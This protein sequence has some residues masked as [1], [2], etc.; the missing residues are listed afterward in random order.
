MLDMCLF[1]L[2]HLI[3][4]IEQQ[5]QIRNVCV[6]MFSPRNDNIIP[7][8]YMATTFPSKWWRLFIGLKFSCK[9]S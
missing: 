8:M 1:L 6:C 5:Q 3:G 7:G 2:A 9:I 4:P